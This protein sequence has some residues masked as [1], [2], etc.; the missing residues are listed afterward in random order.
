MYDDKGT[1]AQIFEA[2]AIQLLMTTDKEELID[3][4]L[5]LA[6]MS[7][8]GSYFKYANPVRMADM[9]IDAIQ[10]LLDKRFTY[11]LEDTSQ[12]EILVHKMEN[13][14]RNLELERGQVSTYNA[15]GLSLE[16]ANHSITIMPDTD[17]DLKTIFSKS[18]NFKAKFIQ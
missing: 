10:G 8:A 15:Q 9:S 7:R 11:S 16:I 2:L 18:I 17:T 4:S 13:W 14:Y 5:N 12:S 1:W 6:K 3:V